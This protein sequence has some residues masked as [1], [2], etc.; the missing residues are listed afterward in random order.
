MYVAR[1]DSNQVVAAADL[2]DGL[3]WLRTTQRSANAT[4][5]SNA[6]DLHARMGHAPVDVLRRMVTSHMIKDAHIPSKPNGSSVCRGC[7]EGKMV[8]KPFPS[9]R[10]K[11][12]Y[13]TFEIL[14]FDICG[15][16]EEKSLG[17]SKYLLLIVDEAS[18]CMKGFCLHSKSESEECIQEVHHDDT[19][20]V[21]QEGQICATRWSPRGLRRTRSKISTKSKASSN[22]PRCHTHIKPME[23]LNARFELSSPSVVACSIMPSWTSASGLKRQ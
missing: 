22:K 1:K 12:T 19:D 18:G 14:H 16:M 15:P 8:Q 21:Q 3:Y 5:L 2:V 6:V 10:D 13:N 9:N 17:G 20:A 11:R 4:S 23:L 7:Q